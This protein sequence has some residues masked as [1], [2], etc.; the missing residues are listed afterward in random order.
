MYQSLFVLLITVVKIMT[1]LNDCSATVIYGLTRQ[2]VDM[3]FVFC[4]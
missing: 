4:L 1:N 3:I 2:Y